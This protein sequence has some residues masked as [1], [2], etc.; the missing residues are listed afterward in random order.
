MADEM[1]DDA[2]QTDSASGLATGM[3]VLTGVMLLV[4][5]FTMWK[6]LGTHYGEGPLA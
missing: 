1:D 5:I 2:P 6:L 4:A 3:I